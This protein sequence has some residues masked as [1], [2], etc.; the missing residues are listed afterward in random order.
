MT[1]EKTM[2]KV[3]VFQLQ[4]EEYT[5]PVDRVGSIERMMTYTRVPRTASFVKGVINLRGVVTPII[6]LRERFGLESVEDSEQTRIITVTING[7]NVGLIVDA[8]NDV[9]D[10]EEDSIEPPPEVV[11]TVEAEYIQG[12]VK[13]EQRLLILLNM[14]KVLSG[15]DVKQLQ[16]MDV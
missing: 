3:I 16:E 4:D 7:M 10:I 9:L 14:S 2:I 11:G 6:D 13:F 8:A 1:E 5:I 12:V 15:D